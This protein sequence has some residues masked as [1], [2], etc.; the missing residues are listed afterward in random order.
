MKKR[1]FAEKVMQMIS[2]IDDD[3]GAR[4]DRTVFLESQK[5]LAELR[6]LLD[7]WKNNEEILN[8]TTDI[9]PFVEYLKTRYQRLIGS[10]GF[11]QLRIKNDK[12][13][14]DTRANK[15]CISLAQLL[16]TV[17]SSI[18]WPG[19]QPMA[20]LMP[21]AQDGLT[22][23]ERNKSLRKF[24]FSEC[25]TA[26]ELLDELVKF[27]KKEWL[28][29]LSDINSEK[30]RAAFFG[31]KMPVTQDE[32]TCINKHFSDNSIK[33]IAVLCCLFQ[34]YHD[35]RRL[36]TDKISIFGWYNK[37]QKLAA[38]KAAQQYL[39]ECDNLASYQDA[40]SGGLKMHSGALMN[41]SL[42]L[43]HNEVLNFVLKQTGLSEATSSGRPMGYTAN[44]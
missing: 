12:D 30:L 24:I 13:R 16:S 5:S 19:R 11:Y 10:S 23:A 1:E 38:A 29:C 18:K 21:A 41:G 33:N 22:E 39:L 44:Y 34:I 42:S 36:K 6:V 28:D 3:D 37:S 15:V 26:S 8:A 14:P 40:L 25:M 32:M 17:D 4:L 27:N 2:K 43:Y 9:D 7:R 31:E 35:E 20:F